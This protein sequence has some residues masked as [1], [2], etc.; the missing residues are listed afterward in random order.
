M[1]FLWAYIISNLQRVVLPT[2]SNLHDQSPEKFKSFVETFFRYAAFLSIGIGLLVTLFSRMIIYLLY[3]DLYVQ[4]IPVLQILVWAFVMAS[5]RAILE[6][7][8]LASDRQKQYF[9]GMIFIAVMYSVLTPSLVYVFGINGAAYAALV[10]ELS[11]LIVLVFL[12]VKVHRSDLW[13][14][15]GKYFIAAFFACAVLFICKLPDALNLICIVAAY[16]GCLF[17]LKAVSKSELREMVVIVRTVF[18]KQDL[19][20]DKKSDL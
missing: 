4:S 17:L 20:L 11:Y 18:H 13:I 14:S 8:L 15:T 6:I 7:A 3:S 9:Y 5:I 16:F 10:T 19:I 1:I 2:L 12:W